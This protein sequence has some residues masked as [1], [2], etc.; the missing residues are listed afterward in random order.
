MMIVPPNRTGGLA[1]SDIELDTPGTNS[2]SLGLFLHAGADGLEQFLK[3]VPSPDSSG[4]D[5][6]FCLK[7]RRPCSSLALTSKNRKAF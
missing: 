1:K 4:I 2:S 5:E 7:Y 3:S 6:P